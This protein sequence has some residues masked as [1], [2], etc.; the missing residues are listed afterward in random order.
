VL[1]LKNDLVVDD[2]LAIAVAQALGRNELT[3]SEQVFVGAQNG[4]ITL[5]GQ[6]G[7]T[8]EREA[9]EAI[10][11]RIPQVC[12]VVNYLRA[13]NVVVDPEEQQ[14]RQPPIG[15]EV[16]T[17][18]ILLGLVERVVINPRNRRVTAFVV[19]GNFPDPEATGK[20]RLPDDVAQQERRVVIHIQ[21]VRCETD[22]SVLIEISSGEAA[23]NRD[24]EPTDFVNPPEGLQ[25]P[26]PYRRD[27]VLFDWEKSDV[28]KS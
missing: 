24:Y 8:D 22:S 4:V 10:A 20:R 13:P 6:V 27:D 25:P 19:H 3:R 17:T 21:A 18:D 26:Y 11:A 9:A 23:R 2:S 1:G 7:N 15:R 5:N 28:P 16:Y 14:L 12:G